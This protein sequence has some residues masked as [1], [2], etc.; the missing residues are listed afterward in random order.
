MAVRDLLERL[1]L[2]QVVNFCLLE[3][4]KGLY[5]CFLCDAV[6]EVLI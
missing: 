1:P 5:V 4:K 2:G 6:R 3:R